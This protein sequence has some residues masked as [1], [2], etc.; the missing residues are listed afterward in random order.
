MTRYIIKNVSNK[1][2]VE[3]RNAQGMKVICKTV[4]PSQVESVIAAEATRMTR[5]GL[6][7]QVENRTN[8]HMDV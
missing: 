1:L 2:V 4:L 7:F 6:K 3:K 5:L 8:I